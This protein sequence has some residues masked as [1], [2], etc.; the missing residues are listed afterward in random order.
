MM[1]QWG[2]QKAGNKTGTQ[3]QEHSIGL[4]DAEAE[5]ELADQRCQG[6][7]EKGGQQGFVHRYF[8]DFCIR[9]GTDAD[10]HGIE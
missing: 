5:R 7:P 10:R 6:G 2:N 9:E 1:R 3:P 8:C 4:T